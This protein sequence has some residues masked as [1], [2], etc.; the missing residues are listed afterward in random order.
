MGQETDGKR[1]RWNSVQ[2]LE[3]EGEEEEGEGGEETT[4]QWKIVRRWLKWRGAEAVMHGGALCQARNGLE[5]SR[6]GQSLEIVGVRW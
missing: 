2:P 4:V 5:T 3:E 1:C 6:L